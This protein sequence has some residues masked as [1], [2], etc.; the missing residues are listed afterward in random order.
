VYEDTFG[1]CHLSERDLRK[2]T[3]EE[4]REIITTVPDDH[5][6]C[7]EGDGELRDDEGY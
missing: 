5:C 1:S 7:K 2:M 6:H 3:R 4:I